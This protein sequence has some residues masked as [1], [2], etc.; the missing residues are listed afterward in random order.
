MTRRECRRKAGGEE[1]E[2]RRVTRDRSDNRQEKEKGD[3]RSRRIKEERYRKEPR[4]SNKARHV[5]YIATIKRCHSRREKQGVRVVL[6]KLS[7]LSCS[8]CMCVIIHM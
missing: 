1:R 6:Q 4:V 8:S 2:N 3:E 5:H 7:N